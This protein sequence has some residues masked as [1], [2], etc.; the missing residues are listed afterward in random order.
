MGRAF[1]TSIEK[2][3]RYSGRMTK[4]EDFFCSVC[5]SIG[6]GVRHGEMERFSDSGDSEILEIL[7]IL[8]NLD[9]FLAVEK[10]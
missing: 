10:S 3:V 7:E 1:D 8:E 5:A 2:V 4:C 6:L 9:R